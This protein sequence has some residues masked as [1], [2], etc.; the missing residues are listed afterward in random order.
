MGT[1]A[2]LVGNV[3]QTPIMKTVN[4]KGEDRRIVELRVMSSSYRRTDDGLEQIDEKT[5]PVGVTI[6]NEK[7]AERVLK[8]I[9]TGASVTIEGD[10]FVSP[11][12]NDN[13]EPQSGIHMDA[14]SFSLNL[15]RVE[16]VVFRQRNRETSEA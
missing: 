10:L 1:Y 4:V 5:F 2:K 16:E 9:K 7:L 6:W 8:L 3:L 13:N 14:E 15:H 11:W 12:L